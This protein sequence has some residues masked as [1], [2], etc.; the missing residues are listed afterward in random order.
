[1]GPL[2]VTAAP[3]LEARGLTKSFGGALALDGVDLTVLP[4]EVHG[5]LGENGSG[6]S[7]LIKILAAYH[8]PDGGELSVN[9]R[10][11]ALPL[12][13]GEPQDLGLEFVHQDL[14]LVPSLTVAENL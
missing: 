6:K 11:V 1:M 7:T 5:L 9:G 4:G 10:D 8:A 2:A 14:G 12:S 3:L 13:P